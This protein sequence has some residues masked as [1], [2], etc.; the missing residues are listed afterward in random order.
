MNYGKKS[1]ERK[2]KNVSSRKKKYANKVMLTFGKTVFLCL[3]FIALL[4]G[5]LAVGVFKG[6]IDNAPDINV[7]SIVPMGFATT[8]YNAKGEQTDTLVMAGSNREEATYDELPQNLIDAF[9]S[10]ED[11]RFW[12]HN[13]IDTRSIMRAIVGVLKH[14]SS[15]GGGSTI[16]QQLIKNNVFNGGRERSFGATLERKIQEWYLAVRLEK[17][18][19][20]KLII[21]N[22]LNTINLGNN[23]LGVK[24]AARRYF[25][26]E[27]SQLTLSE[28]AVIAGITKNPSRLNPITGKE[29]NA[30]R[31]MTIL[32]NMYT[33]GYITKEE[34][35]DA[36]AEDV[37]ARI[38]NVNSTNKETNNTY[39]YFTDELVEQVVETLVEKLGYTET[40][41]HN[42]LYSGGLSIYTTQDPDLQKIVD[43]EINDPSN[44]PIV[45]YSLEYRLSIRDTDG[46]TKNYS[47]EHIKKWHSDI[48]K[49]N[50]DGLY[51]TE[52]EAQADVNKYKESIIQNGDTIIGESLKTVLEPQTSFVLMDQQTGQVKAISGGRGEKTASLTLNRA[53]NTTRQPG[54]TF[55][56][57]TAFGPA[58][59]MG[60]ATLGTVYYDGP[61]KVG[62]KEFTNWYQKE[63][64][65]TGWSS[66][67][68]G[69]IYSM[70]IVAV[71]CLVETVTPQVGVDYAKK[72]GITTLT[73]GDVNAATALGGI[74]KGVSNLELTAAYAAI[75]NGG[76]YT[77]PVFFTKI[78]DHNGKT[79]IDNE[80]ETHRVIKNTT[81]FLLTDA[82]KDSMETHQKFT[83]PGIYISSTSTRAH[84]SN[85]SAAGK[86]G[87][88]SG[89]NDVWFVGF[90]P[91]YTGGIWAGYDENQKLDS[92]ANQTA[93]HK[94]IWRK[95]MTKVN[96]GLDDPGFKAPDNIESAIICRKSGKLPTPGVCEYDPRGDA[97]YK[98]YF[99]KG[100]VPTE[101]CDKH[102]KSGRGVSILVPSDD[103]GNTDDSYYSG[104]SYRSSS[105]NS[106]S[107]NSKS[108]NSRKSSK[109]NSSITTPTTE[110]TTLSPI[111]NTEA[112]TTSRHGSGLRDNTERINSGPGTNLNDNDNSANS[113]ESDPVITNGPGS[114]E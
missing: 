67:R 22:Y 21:T 13:G 26:K 15:S 81:A 97:R 77:K 94:D 56:V 79:L 50:F 69:I 59:D 16:T 3:L 25:G 72:F 1:T 112:P 52:A 31:R 43:K 110:A 109:K 105:K 66:I 58:I 23:T 36:L 60:K 37:Y 46:N 104:G 114:D 93:F 35:E 76:I 2:L 10:I 7:E 39:S 86:S 106:N 89:N 34:E 42:L 28:C 96:Q 12:Q 64:G 6:I 78:I 4:I 32:Q 92:D 54:S 40:Q 88:T 57:L 107:S 45:K 9:V 111:V 20:K 49:D 8:V 29:D 74:T 71:R 108:S 80:P 84:L 101:D 33:Q 68:D 103:Q 95:I 30:E 113:G 91:H 99:A 44:Y 102:V 87:T 73:D 14:N 70:N 100:T 19:D 18:M 61:Y 53:T 82:M 75:A 51:N 85:M 55:K 63:Q 11:S 65:Y 27:V 41:A 98:E 48:L 24:V 62:D 47:Q 90:T 17:T 83:R 38:Q 5:S